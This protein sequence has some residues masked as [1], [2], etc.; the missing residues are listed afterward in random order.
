MIAAMNVYHFALLFFVSNCQPSYTCN[1]QSIFCL[2]LLCAERKEICIH[3]DFLHFSGSMLQGILTSA[4]Q[5]CDRY[6]GHGCTDCKC[7]IHTAAF[8]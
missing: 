8:L 3:L 2:G 4:L 7:K 1:Y 6:K 5:L